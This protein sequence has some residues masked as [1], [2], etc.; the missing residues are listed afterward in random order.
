MMRKLFILP[1]L[2]LVFWSLH[3]EAQPAQLTPEEQKAVQTIRDRFNERINK[4]GRL[5]A[6][7]PD[8]FVTDMGTRYAKER[9]ADRAEGPLIL[10][11]PGIQYK[12]EVLD[13]A[14]EADWRHGLSA[15][16]NFMHIIAAPMLN[17]TIIAAKTGEGF[18]PDAVGPDLDKLISP[19]VLALFSK[20]PVLKNYLQKEGTATPIATVQDLRR[21]A[22]ILDKAHD[23]ISANLSAADRQLTP[24]AASLIK[25]MMGG[26][27]EFGPWLDVSEREVYG[28]PKGTRFITFFANPMEV[29]MITKIGTEYK[30]VSAQISSPD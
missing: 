19:Q 6:L 28:F 2:I 5:E 11:T 16:F 26:D 23:M 15:S 17:R 4:E 29:L 25:E 22:D 7:I 27:K 8:M 30:I 9:K 12:R 3:V 13:S 24:E 14:T 1:L 18:D 20:D 21:V 10:L